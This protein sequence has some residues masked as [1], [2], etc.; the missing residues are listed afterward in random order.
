MLLDL[1]FFLFLTGEA[2]HCMRPE[3]FGDSMYMFTFLES[4]LQDVYQIHGN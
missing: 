4:L 3:M 1:S 2:Q